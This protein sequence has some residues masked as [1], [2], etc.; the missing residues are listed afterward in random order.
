MQ[1]PLLDLRAQYS[2]L[3]AEILETVAELYFLLI[4]TV[5]CCAQGEKYL[6]KVDFVLY[7]KD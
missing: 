2:P 3:K 5:F 7:Y 4:V 6:Q 1:V